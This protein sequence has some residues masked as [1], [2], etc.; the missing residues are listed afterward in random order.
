MDAFVKKLGQYVEHH[1]RC[2][3]RGTYVVDVT[4]VKD[5]ALRELSKGYVRPI[6]KTHR[7]FLRPITPQVDIPLTAGYSTCGEL[8]RSVLAYAFVSDNKTYLFLKPE[9]YPATSFKHVVGAIQR[10]VLKKPGGS[11]SV[12]SRREDE[13]YD[14]VLAEL[15]KRVFVTN[16]I[17]T[18]NTT[19]RVGNEMYIPSHIVSH[20]IQNIAGR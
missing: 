16:N 12:K 19:V 8:K 3:Q 13:R 9:T 20:I 6:Q 17:N 11:P 15:N 5:W 4:D 1:G 10:Y 2:F 18:Y 14:K 7:K